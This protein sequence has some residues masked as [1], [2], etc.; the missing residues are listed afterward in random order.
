MEP[1]RRGEEMAKREARR[2]S[3]EERLKERKEK[4]QAREKQRKEAMEKKTGAEG[5]EEEQTMLR[6]WLVRLDKPR[7]V[8]RKGGRGQ[9]EAEGS[10]KN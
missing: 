4:K 6:G 5:E 3:R 2:I 1:S 8:F 10:G 9:L 7:S